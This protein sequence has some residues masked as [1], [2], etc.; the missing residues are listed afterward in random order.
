MKI[1]LIL[2]NILNKLCPRL[3]FFKNIKDGK[4]EIILITFDDEKTFRDLGSGFIEI[5]VR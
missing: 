5:G 3:F 1:I 2:P 4:L